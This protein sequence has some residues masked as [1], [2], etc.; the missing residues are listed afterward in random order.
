MKK[1]AIPLG[2]PQRVGGWIRKRAQFPLQRRIGHND[3]PV[4]YQSPGGGDS[5]EIRYDKA[6]D[7]YEIYLWF[8][9]E[10]QEMWHNEI[11][12]ATPD[13]RDAVIELLKRMRR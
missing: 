1:K 10:A 9:N 5:Y 7:L 13:F 3:P 12:L 8:F 11:E 2:L 6:E 4:V